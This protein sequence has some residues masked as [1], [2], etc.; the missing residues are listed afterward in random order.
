MQNLE[1]THET[2]Y[3]LSQTGIKFSVDDFG[4]GY[5]SLTYL[6]RF[7][8]DTLKI[9]RSFIKDIIKDSDDK[10]ITTAIIAMAHSLKLQVVAE[11][12]ETMEQMEFL[13]SLQCE[14]MQGFLFYKP[15]SLEAF[16]AL[17]KE[18]KVLALF[19]GD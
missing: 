5:S 8:I 7:P 1:R 3:Q 14:S 19:S 13:R 10:A 6:K 9:D 18:G 11:G 2:L 15:L 17:L 12:V 16:K 4:T